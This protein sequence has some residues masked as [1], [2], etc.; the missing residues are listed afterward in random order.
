MSNSTIKQLTVYRKSCFIKRSGTVSLN[1]G[2]HNIVLD[3][4]AN[5]I[6]SSTLS[7]SLQEGIK[8]SNVQIELLDVEKQEE[9]TKEI[10]SKLLKVDNMIGIKTNQIEMWK[11]N[12]DF[13]N[14][15]TFDISQMSKFIEE[16]PGKLETIYD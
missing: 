5:T 3:T 16:L 11:A 10:R 4:L 8:G 7:V 9:I 13:S 2:R 14:H 12:S 1:K 6:D 15:N